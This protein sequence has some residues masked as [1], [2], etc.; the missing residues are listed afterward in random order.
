[1][2]IINKIKQFLK[3]QR[4]LL[5]LHG[6][7]VRFQHFLKKILRILIRAFKLPGDTLNFLFQSLKNLEYETFQ[8][9]GIY[10]KI[11]PYYNFQG[12]L[13]LFIF[14]DHTLSCG[15]NT[16]VQRIVRGLS[17]SLSTHKNIIFVEWNEVNKTFYSISDTKRESLL[18]TFS[19]LDK[20]N[21]TQPLNSG[22]KEIKP[23]PMLS[24]WLIV[25]EVP[26]LGNKRVLLSDIFKSATKLSLKT[27]ALFYDATPISDRSFSSESAGNHS[28]YMKSLN[29]FDLVF[30]ISKFSSSHLSSFLSFDQNI[31]QTTIR[32]IEIPSE[33]IICHTKKSLE[34]PII[35]ESYALC[36]GS[37]TPHKNSLL[38]TEAFDLLS[39]NTNFSKFKLVF[40]G[41]IDPSI[42]RKFSNALKQN[43]NIIYLG[44]ID[45]EKLTN[46]YQN[47]L[48]TIFPSTSEGYG[49]PIIESLKFNKPCICFD[50]GAPLEV[51]QKG[52]CL[53]VDTADS[54]KLSEAINLLFFDEPLRDNLIKQTKKISFVNWE[55]YTNNLLNECKISDQPNIG[56]I[57]YWVDHTARYPSNTGIQRVV[58]M[59]AKSLI[60][61]KFNLIPVIW[62]AKGKKL[63]E[64]PISAKKNISKYNGPLS[65][66]WKKFPNTPFKENDWFL[67]PELT[68]EHSS[69]IVKFCK[70]HSLR[71]AWIFYDAIP[72]K[73]K[74]FYNDEVTKNHEE[75]MEIFSKV[76]KVLSISHTSNYDLL[77]FLTSKNINSYELDKKILPAL[78]PGEFLQKRNI[79]IKKLVRKNNKNTINILCV[80]TVEPRKNH[81]NLIKAIKLLNSKS[82][83]KIIFTIAG[84]SPYSD[85]KMQVLSE[86]QDIPNSTWVNSPSDSDLQKLY[87]ESTF[88]VYPSIEE[89][90]GLPILESLWNGKPC[91]CSSESAM[92]EVAEGGGCLTTDVKKPKS[93]C[94]AMITLIN[95]TDKYNE[96]V[97][98][99]VN[100]SFKS[101]N[102][103]S[104][105]I[106]Y[107]LSNERNIPVPNK[108]F[109][110][111]P[112]KAIFNTLKNLR[113][114]PILSI[115]ISTFNRAKFLNV[116]LRHLFRL[117]PENSSDV[118]II[119][120]D[121]ASFDNTSEVVKP[122]LYRDDFL[123][124][125]NKKNVGMV[126]NLYE[127][128]ILANGEYVW[129]IGDDDLIGLD[130]ISKIKNIITSNFG[131]SLLYLN[132]SYTNV[133]NYSIS[134]VDKIINNSTPVVE[135]S[136]DSKDYIYNICA[137]SGN[138]F[139]G[140]Y[141]IIFRRDHAIKTF[142]QNTEGRPFSSML[143]SI[144][145]TYYILNNMMNEKAYW[146]GSPSITV[147]LNVS[148][149]KFA[150]VWILARLP[151]AISTAKRY[152]ASSDI[153]KWLDDLVPHVVHWF[154]IIFKKNKYKES[155]LISIRNLIN[156][157]KKI[158]RFNDVVFE[159]RDIYKQAYKN[160]HPI[161]IEQPSVI[162]GYLEDNK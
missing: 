159:M 113:P 69:L 1:M 12:E 4:E 148:W 64:A 114:N 133:K 7:K 15:V 139:T 98:E 37:I 17:K 161:A 144:P 48:F 73:V 26:Y 67:C 56:N 149:K 126:G 118:E 8:K 119:V 152:G 125:R 104:N 77:N 97:L 6:Y 42:S 82:D 31:I 141:C 75:Y 71:M 60:V 111:A 61:N 28:V 2:R 54:I 150:P 46:L 22:L 135:P 156:T 121:N 155:D 40:V 92:G 132:Y 131:I 57:Y 134:K 51:S 87:E 9:K 13:E 29:M 24:S 106:I 79:D 145:T 108:K 86:L 122:F 32:T 128:A 78:L 43:P 25:P 27:A 49:L 47:C 38:L 102:E 130:T 137:K 52:G 140:I 117:I 74:E 109:D 33:N 116:T 105:E 88:T 5:A 59:L 123:Y 143:T 41:N 18:N 95:N 147:N 151:E 91:I 129:L 99:S 107:H 83:S 136:S 65:S 39:T 72:A 20:I 124:S 157:F 66:G 34:N 19:Y 35:K 11:S 101:W 30:P 53:P 93:L 68:H 76:N 14:V 44:N 90:F 58:R 96:L 103:Y 138:I 120:C 23:N 112:S 160:G 45:D 81:L 80:G 36:V 16:G 84:N 50:Q 154:K 115:C 142:S 3:N 127:T 146:V 21:T 110:V 94:R 62:D 162:F 89:G 153:D 85:L 158:P 70:H 100:R 63:I 10:K 55:D